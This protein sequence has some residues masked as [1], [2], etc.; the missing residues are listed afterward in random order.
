MP[1]NIFQNLN[2][3]PYKPKPTRKPIGKSLR[4]QVWE[5]Y[6]GKKAEGKCYCCKIRTIHW[7]DFQVGHNKAVCKGG[8]NHISNLRPICSVCNRGMKTKSIEQYKKKH[9]AK[10]TQKKPEK[11]KAKR[12]NSRD[13]FGFPKLRI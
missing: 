1:R 5:K 8:K 2:L 4:I 12:K 6:M 9:F 11:V 7:S 10:P 3:L 13:F